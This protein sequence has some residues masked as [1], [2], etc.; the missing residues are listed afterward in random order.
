M[1]DVEKWLPVVVALL[2]GIGVE[3][4]RQSYVKKR[5]DADA[6][7]IIVDSSILVSTEW[8]RIAD[9]LR[10]EN[11]HNKERIREL[12]HKVERQGEAINIL[13]AIVVSDDAKEKV[14]KILDD[15]RPQDVQG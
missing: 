2:S 12:E 8:K 7:K 15:W 11:A 10:E 9:T 1:L 5:S 4:V 3:I 13:M 14:K 6:G